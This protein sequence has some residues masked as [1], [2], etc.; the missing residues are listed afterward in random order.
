M[1]M[2][3]ALVLALVWVTGAGLASAGEVPASISYQG[4]LLDSAGNPQPD[5]PR[6]MS[7]RLY[8]SQ[9][10]GTLLWQAGPVAVQVSGGLFNAAIEPVTEADLGPDGEVWLETEVEGQALAPRTRLLSS[11]FA[12]RA[13]SATNAWSLTGNTGTDAE[14]H[15]VGTADEQPLEVRVNSARAVRIEPAEATPNIVGGHAVNT[16][17][18]GVEGVFIGGGG[19]PENTGWEFAVPNLAFDSFC[20][21]GGGRRNRAGSDDGDLYNGAEAVIGGGSF[22]NAVGQLS[23]VGGGTGNTAIGRT[24]GV[25]SG[26][27]SSS[28]G[29]SAFVGGGEQNV[30]GGF[31]A[32]IG[33]GKGNLSNKNFC[34]VGGGENNTA[35]LPGYEEGDGWTTVGGGR[36]NV[37]LV[38]YATV[39]GGQ[40]NEANG[41]FTAIGGGLSNLSGAGWATIAGGSLNTAHGICGAVPGGVQ[42]SADGSYSFAAGRRAKATEEG[43]FVWAD[44]QDLDFFATAANEFSVRATGGVRFVSA[45]DELGEPSAGV[46]LAA[47]DTGWNVISDRELK[48]DLAG[49]DP[50]K[51][52]EQVGSMPVQTWRLKGSAAAARHMGP[53][54]QD[55]AAAFGLGSD[56]RRINTVDA[57]GVALA[58]IQ[59]LYEIVREQ[60]AEIRELKAQIRQISGEKSK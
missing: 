10:G 20:F 45:V 6:Q 35:G 42:N 18:P 30:A 48:A 53:T 56:P 37:A 12:L 8:T 50:R 21:I 49:V 28:D 4:R 34:V 23:F 58:A 46:S 9:S 31:A 32:F 47:G 38:Q 29:D 52:L 7:F 14:V 19:G 57:D 55:F 44:S 33:G 24:S 60:A 2:F 1:R 16:A 43:S 41:A 51:V 40:L 22:N 54:A 59:G 15:Y 39:A 5:G 11:P 26:L 3:V 25:A 36:D 17:S 13:G 27:Y